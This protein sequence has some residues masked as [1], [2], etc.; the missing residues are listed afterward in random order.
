MLKFLNG[1]LFDKSNEVDAIVNTVNCV[2][3]MG[4][5]VALEF[6]KRYPDNYKIYKQVCKNK[7]L[8]PG[9]MLTVKNNIQELPKFI[10]NF[11]TKK[12]WRHPSKIEYIKSGLIALKEEINE[13]SIKSIAM[14]ALGCGN[15][16]LDWKVVKKLIIDELSPFD[17]VTFYIYEPS[18][19][20][21]EVKKEKNIRITRQR[22]LLM[23]LMDY[24][25]SSPYKQTVT[26][27]EVNYLAFILQYLGTD[28]K[29]KFKDIENGPFDSSLN[30]LLILLKN[31]EYLTIERTNTDQNLI[32]INK[33]KFK[34]N[35]YLKKTDTLNIYKEGI[36]FIKGFETS[37]RLKTLAL[38]IWF[39]K[40]G[41]EEEELFGVLQ[42]WTN[43]NNQSISNVNIRDA[44]NRIKKF[45][46]PSG[47]NMT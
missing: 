1:N 25:N 37:E 23:L 24:Y 20:A 30:K 47:E 19:N 36:D 28:F 7:E 45:S 17:D 35:N 16:G 10:I 15:G 41:V 21:K 26:F 29:L 22:S 44:V 11:P 13:Y 33:K 2:G 8:V 18:F 5:G 9:K 31:N 40:Q 4:K 32:K 27:I 3:V 46:E 14:P 42:E 38:T 39:L 34:Q 6:K 43:T 12:H